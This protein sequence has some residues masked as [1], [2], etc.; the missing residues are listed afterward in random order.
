MKLSADALLFDNDGT[1][2]SSLRSVERCWGQWAVE[3]GVG[4]EDFARIELHG[5]PS[6][7]IVADL[8]PPGR[9]TEANTRIEELEIADAAGTE[10]LPGT[11]RLLNSLP[12]ERWAVVTSATRRLALARLAGVGV[13]P[14]TLVAADDITRGKPDPE[15]YLLAAARLGVDPARCVVFED[16]PVGLRSAHAAGMKSVALTT[17]YP[18][19]QLRADAV[20]TDLSQVSVQ[21][22]EAGL[23]ILVEDTDPGVSSAH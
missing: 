2:I 9:V 14:G 6:V 11:V 22:G 7:E 23:E 3:Y 21:V 4:A 19:E 12:A 15:P 1:L 5:R 17:T 16:A 10:A 18:R 13:R 20:V 8:V